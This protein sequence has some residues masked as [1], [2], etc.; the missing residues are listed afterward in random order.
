MK[1]DIL[2]I[3]PA[4]GGAILYFIGGFDKAMECLI[5]FMLLD[6][7]TGVAKAYKNKQVDSTI[8]FNGIK[9]KCMIIVL[10]IV[11]NY[12]DMLMNIHSSDVNWRALVMWVCI[13]S[14]GVSIL[15][16]IAEF[17]V[18][19]PQQLLDALAKLKKGDIDGKGK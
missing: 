13:G 19:I 18:P 6:Y 12:L 15:E 17:G 1:F 9:K 3:V 11:A 5:V 14:E 16:N 7:I 8:G 2:D 4:T 10:L